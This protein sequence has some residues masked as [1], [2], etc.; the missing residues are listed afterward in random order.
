MATFG[1]TGQPGSSS[2]YQANQAGCAKFTLSE[3][4]EVSK[5]TFYASAN[6]GVY[7]KAC[8]WA[9]DGGSGEPGTLKGVS[10][11][12]AVGTT[13]GFHDFTFASPIS[14]TAGDY[15]LGFVSGGSSFV[16][17]Y[18]TEAGRAYRYDLGQTYS[19]PVNWRNA[20]DNHLDGYTMGVYA[21]YEVASQ[22]T[23]L[24]V[25]GAS[26]A[27]SAEAPILIENKAL[28]V[29]SALHDHRAL[30]AEANFTGIPDIGAY[31]YHPPDLTLEQQAVMA[32]ADGAHAQTADT[33]ALI[34]AH[35][36]APGDA[37]HTHG[38]EAPALSQAH[39]L[40]M[41]DAG[42]GQ[43]AE[44]PALAQA[45][46]LEVNNSGHDQTTEG[47]ALTQAHNLDIAGADH[48][49]TADSVELGVSAGDTELVV[50][51]VAHEHTAEGVELIED[52]PLVVA[53]VA[54][55]H[56][57][58]QAEAN[59]TGTPDIGAYEYQPP[60]LTLEQAH[61]LDVSDSAHAQGADAPALVQAHT[62]SPD[63]AVHAHSADAVNLSGAGT[64]A[65]ADADHAHE[66]GSPSI[67]QAHRLTVSDAAHWQTAEALTLVQAHVLSLVD[68]LHGQMVDGVILAQ[69]HELAVSDGGHDHSADRPPLEV[70]FPDIRLVVAHVLYG[71]G[72][73][74][75]AL[76]QAHR[77]SQ[78]QAVHGISDNL[79]RL[80]QAHALIASDSIH[81]HASGGPVLKTGFPVWRNSIL[82]PVETVKS[83]LSTSPVSISRPGHLDGS[84]LKNSGLSE[85]NTEL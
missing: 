48:A 56:R 78:P 28:V 44:A 19:T 81:A 84:D 70:T 65:V 23:E 59:Y 77:L 41:S 58:L 80:I 9:A 7:A 26:H 82:G 10:A 71:V 57:A 52:V 47:P 60:A 17:R 11:A 67:T 20:S 49:Q 18:T 21:T 16:V 1:N 46:T 62:L 63:E 50:A 29:A 2:S 36:L 66:A 37:A 30:Q 27:Q 14:L 22:D 69:A 74:P 3:D 33:P 83:Y 53:D 43:E 12:V 15:Y 45:H 55:S 40:E 61:T 75:I 79:L 4:G 42:H 8:I 5:V 31:E 68:A 72:G 64:L 51:D 38:A 32:T 24:T 76:T 85:A 35:T 13:L 39:A 34:Q 6:A 73:T 25:A 54:H